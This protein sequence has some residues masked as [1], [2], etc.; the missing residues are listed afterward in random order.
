MNE[1]EKIDACDSC[2]DYPCKSIGCEANCDKWVD[3]NTKEAGNDELIK[4][5]EKCSD[6]IGALKD[7]A[8]DE[9]QEDREAGIAADDSLSRALIDCQPNDF[10]YK[11]LVGII[12]K[13]L[14]YNKRNK[15]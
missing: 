10:G 6:W 7:L 15:Q 4:A 9:M 14:D 12:D 2:D 5:L 11:R 1:K 13:Y 3:H 8:F